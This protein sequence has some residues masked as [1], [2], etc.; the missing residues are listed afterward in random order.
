MSDRRTKAEALIEAVSGGAASA[1]IAAVDWWSERLCD[2]Y[3]DDAQIDTF[4]FRRILAMAL[5]DSIDARGYAEIAVRCNQAVGHLRQSL[6]LAGLGGE[7]WPNDIQMHI[8]ERSV[9]ATIERVERSDVTI[10]EE[11]E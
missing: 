6:Y 3:P 8:S 9:I 11:T 7:T 5:A 4:E 10:W 2:L 1:V